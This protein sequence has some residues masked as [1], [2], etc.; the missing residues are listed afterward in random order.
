MVGDP[1]VILE[2]GPNRHHVLL[3]DDAVRVRV[4][5]GVV[6]DRHAIAQRDPAAVVE[7]HVPMDDD[8]IAHLELVAVRELD[9]LEAL[10][11]LADAREDE[12][13][14]DATELDRHVDIL[15]AHR[16]PVER[17][18]EPEQRLH[19]RE[20]RLVHVGV[21]LG[22]QRDIARIAGIERH[23]G[24]ERGIGDALAP[25]PLTR[26]GQL[27]ERVAD[28]QVP[29]GVRRAEAL[30]EI[31]EPRVA[32]LACTGRKF[33][34][35]ERQHRHDQCPMVSPRTF[36]VPRMRDRSASKRGRFPA[37]SPLAAA[38]YD[39][40]KLSRTGMSRR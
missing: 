24:G 13:R 1:H 28:D 11:V 14:Q 29:V 22:L 40:V 10:E 30:V 37:Q 27:E 12:R 39:T 5:V 32:Q 31:G 4:D 21:I 7:Q 33:D 16:Q 9:V 3:V 23:A 18:P 8:V 35:H 26:I 17:I 2:H 20:L 25:A 15:P 19:A 34:L 6:G 38:R 36:T